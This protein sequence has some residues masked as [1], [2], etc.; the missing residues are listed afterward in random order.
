MEAS[1]VAQ[2]AGVLLLPCQGPLQ[3]KDQAAVM[4]LS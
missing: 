3:R 1:E 2:S 4:S